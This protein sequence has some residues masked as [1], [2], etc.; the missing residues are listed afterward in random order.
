MAKIYVLV[1]LVM[2]SWGFNV[3]ATKILVD[4][5]SPVTMTAYRIFT[6]GVA[7]F[8]IL[9]FLK[10]VRLPTKQELPAVLIGAILNVTGHHFFLAVGL[11][12]TTGINGGI[13]LGFG[14]LL[15]VLLSV[16]LLG[17]RLTLFR[18]LGFIIGFAGVLLTVLHGNAE[19]EGVSMGDV[20]V[21][22]SITSQALSFIVIKKASSTMDPRLLTGYMLVIGSFGLMAL[23]TVIEPDGV[24]TLARG[25]AAAYAIFL[26][27]AVISTAAGHITYNYAIGKIGAA[28]ASIFLNLIPFFSLAG[29]A[30]F[31]HEEIQPSHLAGLVLII[32]GV[33][34]GSGAYKHFFRRSRN[35]EVSS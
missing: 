9:Y 4:E 33:S 15:T 20:G 1:F 5:F 27:A 19:L 17:F 22:L 11:K 25:S 28:E 3:S 18:C 32:T 31:L 14:P 30:L 23:G 24:E 21:L 35:R 29:A 26:A 16:M 6:A 12:H 10:L 8:V 13:I 7:A 2:V 34:I